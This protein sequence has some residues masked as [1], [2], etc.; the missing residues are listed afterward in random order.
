MSSFVV[1]FLLKSAIEADPFI[2]WM[3]CRVVPPVCDYL[4]GLVTNPGCCR[5][6]APK[7]MSTLAIEK[8]LG[9]DTKS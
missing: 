2:N 9:G 8:T 7:S 5:E 1:A 3:A 4:P 6:M